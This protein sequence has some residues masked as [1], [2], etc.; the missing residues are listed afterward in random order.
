MRPPLGPTRCPL[1]ASTTKTVISRVGLARDPDQIT[2][3]YGLKVK[4]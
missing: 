2:A 4:A 1:R 3:V